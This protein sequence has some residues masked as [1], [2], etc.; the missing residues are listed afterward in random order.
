MALQP[1]APD[2]DAG[3]V[4]HLPKTDLHVHAETFGRLMQAVLRRRG[5]PPYSHRTTIERHMTEMPPGLERLVEVNRLLRAQA[6]ACIGTDC[7]LLYEQPDYVEA[8]F[9]QTMEEEAS[10]GS[11]IAELRLG[12]GWVLYP[13]FLPCF[14]SA[15][16]RVRARYP[17][18]VAE[19]IIAWG[20]A[21][22]DFMETVMRYTCEL[23]SEGIAGVDLYPEY[24]RY[25]Y[26]E[27]CRMAER[28]AEAGLGVTCHDGEFDPETLRATL[29]LPGLT[30]MGHAT[31]A[32]R[33][34]GLM[35]EL[36]RRGIVVEVALTSN[37]VLG[38]VPSYEEHPLRRF[39]DAGVRVTLCS[40]DPVTFATDIGREYAIASMLGFS[41]EELRD[42]ARTGIEASF[43]PEANRARLL[44]SLDAP[45]KVNA[46]L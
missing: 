14:R 17:G 39:L 34:P 12:G 22:P 2:I 31:Q 28:A 26:Q 37:V 11:L 10:H 30:R 4:R 36:A 3:A 6:D 23:A 18:F 45:G 35:E 46:M 8:C 32:W 21:A 1:Y 40:D 20:L 13:H 38:A 19:P 42:F 41:E 43:T 9:E 15:E 33:E 16:R 7:Q 27:I 44:A 5:L 25:D 24:R 29:H